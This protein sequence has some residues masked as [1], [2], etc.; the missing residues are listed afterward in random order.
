MSEKKK[1]NIFHFALIVFLVELV[2]SYFI[3]TIF[4]DITLKNFL[5]VAF[6]SLM[7]CPVIVFAIKGMSFA[8][9]GVRSNY[10]DMVKSKGKRAAR[11]AV[12][13]FLLWFVVFVII[14]AIACSNSGATKCRYLIWVP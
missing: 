3:V 9:S 5:L 14:P 7:V 4:L 13:L 1:S 12:L 10:K 6:A 8:V 2:V 11:I